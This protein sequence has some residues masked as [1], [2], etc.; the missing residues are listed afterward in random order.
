MV[1]PESDEIIPFVKKAEALRAKP[2]VSL[3]NDER[4]IV[5]RYSHMNMKFQMLKKDRGKRYQGCTFRNY[6]AESEEQKQVIRRLEDF[7]KSPKAL[8]TNVLLVGP[9]GTGK[10]H[11]LMALAFAIGY[12]QGEIPYWINGVDFHVHMRDR[13]FADESDRNFY[14][15]SYCNPRKTPIL[16]ISDPLPP[17]GVLSEFQQSALVG[18][19]DYRY[20]AM[21]PTWLT[22]NVADS[23]EA[24][25]RMGSQV[26]D[27][28]QH[29]ALILNCNWPSFRTP[30]QA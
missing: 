28:L 23:A 16:W 30:K 14:G 24:S 22:L 10:D 20:A 18:V 5:N 26:V 4:S 6:H 21:L 29:D 13:A 7:A 1:N 25:K 9:Q 19:M 2:S 27:R 11:L 12:F 8:E 15:D 17:S 3:S